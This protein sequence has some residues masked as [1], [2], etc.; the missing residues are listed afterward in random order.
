MYTYQRFLYQPIIIQIY[1]FSKNPKACHGF[2]G[3]AIY[4]YRSFLL[5]S[6][7]IGTRSCLCQVVIGRRCGHELWTV[8]GNSK[9][10]LI[11][12]SSLGRSSSK[13]VSPRGRTQVN[14]LLMELIWTGNINLNSFSIVEDWP[15]FIRIESRDKVL[16]FV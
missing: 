9:N 11:A 10:E 8:M 13:I 15:T 16:C 1:H 12:S 4:A 7:C 6:A 5:M 2:A 3:W 14:L